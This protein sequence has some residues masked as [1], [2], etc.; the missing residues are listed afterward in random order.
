MPSTREI[1]SRLG[2]PHAA[3][4]CGGPRWRRLA[5]GLV[6]TGL[7]VACDPTSSSPDDPSTARLPEGSDAGSVEASE[8]PDRPSEPV[9]TAGN[10]YRHDRYWP[11]HVQLRDGFAELGRDQPYGW[12][13]GVLL[14]VEDARSVRIDFGAPGKYTL[15]IDATDVVE[16]ARAVQRGEEEKTMPNLY[17][18][19]AP[20]LLDPGGDLLENEPLA[21][22]EAH[23]FLLVLSRVESDDLAEIGERIAP[24]DGQHGLRV[25]LF[26]T[27][28]R[29]D[30]QV[31]KRLHE[32][33][34][35]APFLRTTLVE[36]FTKGYFSESRPAPWILLLNEEGR[37]LFDSPW[38]ED[39]MR[40][41]EPLLGSRKSPDPRRPNQRAERP[42]PSERPPG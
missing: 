38:Q 25:V 19:L 6:L 11:Y 23:D 5:T 26:A 31:F 18:A 40:R 41:L 42:T 33:G 10:L 13:F 28:G 24:L 35:R 8:P 3:V 21:R 7:L 14:R 39:T 34:W 15:P 17:R 37:V 30:D 16:R 36:A 9:L 20:R 22:I 32:I 4:R 2:R 29:G 1:R 27:G 12:G